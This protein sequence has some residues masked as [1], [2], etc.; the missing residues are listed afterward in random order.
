MN[1]NKKTT[2][3]LEDV[4]IKLSALW[5]ALTFVWQQGDVM[6]LYSGDVIGGGVDT[7]NLMSQEMLWMVGFMVAYSSSS[8]TSKNN[9]KITID[10]NGDQTKNKIHHGHG[11]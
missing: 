2:R 9:H 6:R 1:T 8:S 10:P 7:G 5:V 11:L 4:Q 3:N